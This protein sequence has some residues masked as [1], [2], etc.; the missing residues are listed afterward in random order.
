VIFINVNQEGLM[1]EGLQAILEKE[2]VLSTVNA[3]D[4]L[5]NAQRVEGDYQKHVA[6]FVPMGDVDAFSARLIKRVVG[7]RTPKGMIVAPYGYGKT[8]TLAFMW[9]EC[10][11]QGLVAVPPFYCAT[12]LDMLK[13]TYGW[14]KFRLEH[15]QP[16]LVADLDEVYSKYTAATVEEMAKRYAQEHG[17]AQ[18]I[19]INMLNDMLEDGSLVLE[20]TPSNLLFFLDAAAA[21]V[22][23]AEFKGLAI[24]ADEFQQYFSK[25][26]NLRRTVQGFREFVWGLDTRA[27]P[28][29]VIFSVPTYAE[30]VIQEQGKDILHRLKKDD[31]YHHLQ[32]IYTLDF[33]TRLWD[34]YAETFRLG[35]VAGQIMGRHT[36]Q[37]IGQ[38]AE[39][40]DL[41]EGPRTVIDSFKRAILCYQD[42]SR[43]YTPI[44]LIDDFLGANI[45]FQAQ[46]N[47]VKTVTRQALD[48]AVADTPQKMQAIKLM[49]A[50]PRGCPVEVQKYYGL[51]DAVVAL[52]KRSHGELLVS[53]AEGDTLLGLS[54]TAGPTHT[55]DIIITRFWQG[56]EEDELHLEA[57]V[58]AFT[59]RLLPRFFQPRRGAAATGWGDLDF[60]TSARGSYIALAEGTFNPQYPHRLLAFQVAYNEAQLQP[61]AQGADFQF[62]FLFELNGHEDPGNLSLVSDRLIRL[63]LNMQQKVGPALPDDIRKLQ[64]FVLPEFVTPLL[65]LSLVDYFDR[66]EEIEEQTVPESDRG[67]IEH[68]IGRLIG[69]TVQ[70][71]FNRGL[72]ES[73]APPLRRVG[74]LVLEELFNRCCAELYPNYRTLFVQAQYE[75][76][77]NDYINAMRDMTLKE[78]RGHTPLRGTK[79]ALAKRFGL[80]SVA[81][82][83]NRIQSDYANLMKK[84]EWKGRGDQGIGEV[85]L[86]LH[87]L[88]VT[89][90]DQLRSS[91]N[92]RT[93]DERRTPVL[94]GNEAANLARELGYRDEETL[95][96]LQLLAARGY[97]RYDAHDK[98]IYLV[99][100]GPDPNELRA[101][102]ERLAADLESVSADLL[103][104]RQLGALQTALAEAR[105]GLEQ[106]SQDEEELDELQ[107]RLSDL[108]QQLSDALSER[109]KELRKQLNDL[110]LEVE[111]SLIV[112]R[113][114]D[115]LDRE[116]Q[117]QVAF[118]MHLNEL[119]QHLA[120][121]RRH[122]ADGYAELKKTLTQAISQT[123]DG[124]VT[125]AL[126]L[127][128]AQRE[129]ERQRD[130]LDKERT[131]LETQVNYLERW[132]K[133][134]KDTDRLF[135]ALAQLP[136]LREQLIHQVVPEIQAYLTKRKLDGLANWEPFQ[137]KV[138]AVEEELEKQRRHGNERFGTVKETYE[139]FLREIEVGDYRPRTRYTYGEDEGSYR[140]LYEEVRMK[141]EG[142]L[143]EIAADLEREQTDLLKAKYIHIVD[144]DNRKLIQQIEKQLANTE[145]TLGQLRRALTVS[146]IQKSGDELAAFGHQVKEVAKS[147]VV[148]Q[149]Q[150]GPILFADHQL[151]PEE[152]QV[153]QAFGSRNGSGIDLTDLFV[154]LL[155]TGQ[156]IELKDLLTTLEGLYRKNR[157]I[158]RVRQRG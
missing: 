101:R 27:N 105:A 34:R 128:R 108:N 87:P 127:H 18:V 5:Q 60:V 86:Q 153:L 15:S 25:G 138:N 29:G 122:L 76:V 145:T 140:D 79:E 110:I 82:F 19:A 132:I 81:T 121:E 64:E 83:E 58:R 118:V 78:R 57:A 84:G 154:G 146:L 155:L 14:I 97:T 48:S 59:S 7:A 135:N 4:L 126:A 47:K 71:L 90:L 147:V 102:L 35:D 73:V 91:S 55:V 98:I 113:Q 2:P 158:I 149:Q 94:S 88:E 99:Q 142:R 131:T 107:T 11:R 157:V 52:S 13:A 24:F 141:I 1:L 39:R 33:P 92:D 80:G 106:A 96:A 67:E 93:L 43:A 36:L 89:I 17:I 20:L 12:L 9:H 70:M 50:F 62:D 129:G 3:D 114:G 150:L 61:L 32:D 85:V 31:L 37:A 152:A 130:A 144:E 49:A 38:I 100:I 116:I 53:L 28:L 68:L 69:H 65:M 23:R 51:R 123:G 112:L 26:A 66:W 10:E 136:D 95:L 151:T 63:H 109:R 74:G 40:D 8:S 111:R 148:V 54:R 115:T 22:V 156:K 45:R 44:D 134:L 16:G 125:E 119:R 139:Q 75:S 46:T 41:G 21:L 6:T 56:Y 133:L 104:A 120:R 42:H 137:V 77:L 143:D 103:P 30:S 117:G 124:P 72:A